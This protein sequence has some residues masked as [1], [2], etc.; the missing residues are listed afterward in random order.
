MV[1]PQLRQPSIQESLVKNTSAVV[2]F[3]PLASKAQ[4]ERDE[5]LV[6]SILGT[7]GSFRSVDE[8]ST[9]ALWKKLD[10]CWTPPSSKRLSAVLIPRRYESVLHDEIMPLLA[11]ASEMSFSTDSW[12][13]KARRKLT[14]INVHIISRITAKPI[15]INL[16]TLPLDSAK[17]DAVSIADNLRGALRAANISFDKVH[18]G[19]GDRASNQTAGIATFGV[20]AMFCNVHMLSTVVKTCVAANRD[21]EAVLD[22][23]H[24]VSV[25]V[26]NDSKHSNTLRDLQKADPSCLRVLEL[27]PHMEVRFLTVEITAIRFIKLK[28]YLQTMMTA[29]DADWQFSDEDWL[30]SEIICK[31]LQPFYESTQY[32]SGGTYPTLPLVVPMTTIVEHVIDKVML[33]V[34]GLLSIDR[35]EQLTAFATSLKDKLRE[36]WD[37]QTSGRVRGEPRQQEARRIEIQLAASLFH[38]QLKTTAVL[39]QETLEKARDCLLRHGKEIITRRCRRQKASGMIVAQNSAP[40]API[41]LGST[42]TSF[43]ASLNTTTSTELTPLQSDLRCFEDDIKRYE[44]QL[45]ADPEDSDDMVYLQYDISAWWLQNKQLFPLLFEVYCS[46]CSCPASSIPAEEI[47]SLGGLIVTKMR[48]SLSDDKVNQLLMLQ[49]NRRR[50]VAKFLKLED[51]FSSATDEDQLPSTDEVLQML[52]DA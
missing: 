45:V 31:L 6:D 30:V 37:F 16:Q 2:S 35:R 42:K 33:E 36:F 48:T 29:F 1:Q 24:R 46:I 34:D 32:L 9:R 28:S 20:P 5:L 7:S 41:S 4:T 8:I 43:I 40:H 25:N 47:F 14:T 26:R 51:E 15:A 3:Y 27:I 49:S 22:K 18:Y 12:K 17:E 19:V 21:I 11:S 13:N 38:P 10:P 39:G 23:M 44:S 50:Q 52:N